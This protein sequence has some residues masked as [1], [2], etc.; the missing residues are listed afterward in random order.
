MSVCSQKSIFHIISLLQKIFCIRCDGRVDCEDKTDEEDCGRAVILSSYNKAMTPPP[1]IGSNQVKVEL[2]MRLQSVLNLDEIGQIM[3]VKYVLLA[4]WKDP[5]LKFHNLKRDANQNVL[6]EIEW[7][8]IWV[9]RIIFDNTEATEESIMDAKSIIRVLANEN[10]THTVTDLH[11]HQNIYVFD[12]KETELEMSR[13]YNTEF[14]CEYSMA[15]YPFDS[16]TCHLDF[17]L[18]ASAAAF[19]KLVNGTLEYWGPVELAQYFVRNTLMQEYV[20]RDRTGVRVL[21]VFGRRL[22][23]NILTVYVPT[24]LLNTMGHITVYFKP[25]FFE[26]IITVNLTVMLVLTTM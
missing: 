25:F 12:G 17:V 8:R 7:S 4:K 13:A 9:P 15:W 26:A 2:S 14:L 22:L 5:G 6:S 19:V 1:L 20:Y 24:V 23:S 21:V 10:F 16:Q 3:F 18:D 11:H